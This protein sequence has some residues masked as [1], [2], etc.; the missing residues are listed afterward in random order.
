MAKTL[1]DLK[2]LLATAND[3]IAQ[4]RENIKTHDRRANENHSNGLAWKE[5]YED[6]LK[7]IK[8]SLIHI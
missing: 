8:L 1:K 2:A 6:A 7:D 4:L 5:K 3:T